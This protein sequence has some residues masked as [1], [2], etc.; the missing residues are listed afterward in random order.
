MSSEIDALHVECTYTQFEGGKKSCKSGR[1]S[2]HVV[3]CFTSLSYNFQSRKRR[4]AKFGHLSVALEHSRSEDIN[5][6]C[7]TRFTFY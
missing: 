6:R 5:M 7:T 4:V 3:K 1:H 2:T